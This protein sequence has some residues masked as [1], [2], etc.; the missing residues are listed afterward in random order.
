MRLDQ[1]TR[2]KRVRAQQEPGDACVAARPRALLAR[3]GV[4][5]RWELT[6]GRL[7]IAI[8]FSIAAVA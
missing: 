7:F 3:P 6:T 2:P 5:R 1:R 4:R 8:G